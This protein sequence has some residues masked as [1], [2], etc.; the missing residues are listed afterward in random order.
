VAKPEWGLKRTCQSCGARF[1]DM[2]RQPPVCPVCNTEFVAEVIGR[3]RRSAP[4]KA[5]AK[6]APKKEAPAAAAE[7]EDI[8]EIEDL[9]DDDDDLIE[10]A[11]DLD[12]DDEDDVAEV[13]EHMEDSGED[14]G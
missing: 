14:K 9:D 7:A 8:D 1:Y 12:D 11:D 10:A 4:A 6:P 13:K 5:V 3:T 2:L